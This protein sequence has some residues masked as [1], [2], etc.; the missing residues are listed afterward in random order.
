MA[1]QATQSSALGRHAGFSAARGVIHSVKGGLDRVPLLAFLIRRILLA[2]PVLWGV[3][4][5]TFTLMNILPGDAAEQLLGPGAS[6]QQLHDLENALHLNEPFFSRY[7]TWFHGVLTGHLGISLTNNEPVAS[8]LSSHLAVT[9]ELVVL[10]FLVA[11]LG[12]VPTAIF[13]ALRPG[14]FIDQAATFV[15]MLGMS[16]PNF[17]FALILI[18]IFAVDLGWLPAVGWSPLGSGLWDNLKHLIMPTIS[19]SLL[20]YCLY[21]RLL[22]G[23]LVEQMESQDYTVAA[24]AKG[25]STIRIV[26]VHALRNSMFGLITVI[27]LNLGGL[28][29]G[30]VIVEQV[31]GLPGVGSL[32]LL[33]I[34]NRD[35]VVVEA[36]VMIV[37]V[38]VVVANVGVDLF[39]SLLDPRIRHERSNV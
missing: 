13:A 1:T 29:G 23:D 25:L 34:N 2:I 10:A 32:L 18:I 6:E 35:V 38:V 16:I 12:A 22:R 14:R 37:A 17:V 4:F 15:T 19:L 9:V 26:V 20:L 11:L 30:T 7:W 21:V 31:F 8:L 28:I 3:T 27:A 33:S 24:R 5:L 36:I 39:Y